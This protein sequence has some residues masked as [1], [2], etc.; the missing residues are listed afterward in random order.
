MRMGDKEPSFEKLIAC[1]IEGG[2]FPETGMCDVDVEYAIK[3]L[4]SP[5][6]PSSGFMGFGSQLNQL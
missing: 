1:S 4:P 5:P 3:T 6:P 2:E